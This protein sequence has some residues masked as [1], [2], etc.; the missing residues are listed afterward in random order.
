MQY[1]G[2]GQAKVIVTLN[3]INAEDNTLGEDKTAIALWDWSRY[4]GGPSAN[5]AKFSIQAEGLRLTFDRS[6]FDNLINH[7]RRAPKKAKQEKATNPNP[8]ADYSLPD[9][10]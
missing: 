9:L 2:K 3:S 5:S 1:T 7:L 6:D 8:Q 4:G 10:P